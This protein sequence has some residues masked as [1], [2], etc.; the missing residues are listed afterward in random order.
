MG[1]HADAGQHIEAKERPHWGV[2]KVGNDLRS[3]QNITLWVSGKRCKDRGY[4]NVTW[5]RKDSSPARYAVETQRRIHEDS[6]PQS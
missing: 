2:K 4:R 1:T 5:H 3:T 6:R